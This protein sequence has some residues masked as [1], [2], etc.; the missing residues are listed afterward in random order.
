MVCCRALGFGLGEA[1]TPDLI[2]FVSR[3]SSLHNKK[4]AAEWP[5]AVL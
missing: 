1:R 2:S 4:V 5:E 3:E